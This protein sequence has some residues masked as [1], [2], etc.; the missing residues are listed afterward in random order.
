MISAS[1]CM[2]SSTVV[3]F[4]SSASPCL[5]LSQRS[6]LPREA[7]ATASLGEVC[8]RR[9]RFFIFI[10]FTHSA[11]FIRFELWSYG[12][13][14]V[15]HTLLLGADLETGPPGARSGFRFGKMEFSFCF[16]LHSL[17]LSRIWNVEKGI[18]SSW[19]WGLRHK[20]GR[21]DYRFTKLTALPWAL[22]TP[23]TR[24]NARRRPDRLRHQKTRRRPPLAP[25]AQVALTPRANLVPRVV[26]AALARRGQCREACGSH[27]GRARRRALG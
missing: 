22:P 23:T 11:K 5:P 8:D 17:Y 26:L 19:A 12:P 27:P 18:K 21:I 7:R 10:F 20:S 13:A 14:V 25:S 3:Q 15:V 1:S 4:D 24:Q 16:I 9:P 2:S 6:N